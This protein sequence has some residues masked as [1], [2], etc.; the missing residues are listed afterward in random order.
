MRVAK[1]RVKNCME[2]R[3][4]LFSSQEIPSIT[5]VGASLI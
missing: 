4:I 2:Y 1:I 3:L 5:R